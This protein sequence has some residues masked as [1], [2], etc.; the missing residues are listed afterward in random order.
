MR[1]SKYEALKTMVLNL[2]ILGFGLAI[3]RF[4]MVSPFET[5]TEIPMR[6]ESSE[7]LG[8]LVKVV[9]V[10]VP[11]PARTVRLAPQL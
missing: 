9:T 6:V 4:W 8:R 11:V 2:S 7:G 5:K 3:G 1:P 10:F